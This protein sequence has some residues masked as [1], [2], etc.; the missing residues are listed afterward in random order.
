MVSYRYDKNGTVG[1]P[2]PCTRELLEEVLSLSCCLFHLTHTASFAEFKLV[3]VD[4]MGYTAKDIYPRTAE[5][6]SHAASFKGDFN[7]ALAGT[8][9]PRG[10]VRVGW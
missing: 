7:S 9:F 3:D 6:F 4:D 1:G 5:E 8:P 2:L 10:E